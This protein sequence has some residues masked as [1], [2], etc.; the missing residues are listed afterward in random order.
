MQD[1]PLPT[2]NVFP[3]NTWRGITVVSF[4]RDIFHAALPAEIPLDI[5]DTDDKRSRSLSVL[6]NGTGGTGFRK[7]LFGALSAN[8]T[9]ELLLQLS[10]ALMTFLTNEQYVASALTKRLEVF[11]RLLETGISAEITCTSHL[12][13]LW[14]EMQTSRQQSIPPLFQHGLL[15]VW[16]TIYALY[17]ARWDDPAL[18]ALRMNGAASPEALYGRYIIQS[19]SD[20]LT[21]ITNRNCV[22]CISPVQAE[23]YVGHSA[24]PGEAAERLGRYGKLLISGIGGSGKS[25]FARLLLQHFN[26]NG[27][28][29]RA[30]YVQYYGSLAESFRHA[31]PDLS[32]T[33]DAAVIEESRRLLEGQDNARTLL[34]IDNMNQTTSEDAALSQLCAYGG[35]VVITSRLVALDGFDVMSLPPL[36]PQDSQRLF[37]IHLQHVQENQNQDLAQLCASVQGHPLSLVLFAGLCRS[38]Y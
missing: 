33:S 13:G 36:S 11:F 2:P 18:I 21:D 6:L 8:L 29:D 12:N 4:W 5:F 14:E 19:R 37:R 16:L 26:S 20:K 25:E 24:L 15:L 9:S 34:M 17:I 7:K 32:A 28:Y 35:H 10:T 22:L 23:S 38:K 27:C 30:A 1:Y 3:P 31:F